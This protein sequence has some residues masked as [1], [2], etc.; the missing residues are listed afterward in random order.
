MTA[1]II[2]VN[3]EVFHQS[4]YCGLKEDEWTNQSHIWLR[5][6]FDSIIK[7]RYG[8]DISPDNFPDI[9]LEGTPLYDM[10]E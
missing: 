8:P 6:K 9:N 2:R 7:D 1:N 5:K 4:T 3:G 10:Y